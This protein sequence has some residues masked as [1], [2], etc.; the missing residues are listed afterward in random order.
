M[1]R[2]AAQSDVVLENFKPGG[3]RALA[4]DYDALRA[5]NQRLVYAS[6]TGFGQTGPLRDRLAYDVF[7]SAASGLM[8]ITGSAAGV[9]AAFFAPGA[10]PAAR[11][12]SQPR[13]AWR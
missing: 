10:Q 6:I 4:V 7:V 3:A 11:A 5:L 8:S 12:Q 9:H 1:R 2:L 13:S